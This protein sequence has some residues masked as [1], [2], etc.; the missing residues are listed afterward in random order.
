MPKQAR[1]LYASKIRAGET[2][3][4]YKQRMHSSQQ[5]TP[6]QPKWKYVVGINHDP[7]TGR[8]ESEIAVSGIN[9]RAGWIMT[10][11]SLQ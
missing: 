5:R 6:T 4:E 10:V 1:K 7:G 3:K 9:P 8:Y 2:K 11:G